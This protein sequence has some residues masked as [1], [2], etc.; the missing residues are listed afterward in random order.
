MP[1]RNRAVDHIALFSVYELSSVSQQTQWT[2]ALGLC[3]LSKS[4]DL[5]VRDPETGFLRAKFRRHGPVH[6]Q[7]F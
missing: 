3:R 6:C 1:K 4:C 2:V 7:T 5:R